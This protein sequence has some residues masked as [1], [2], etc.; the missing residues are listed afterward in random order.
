MYDKGIMYMDYTSVERVASRIKWVEIAA[1][2]KIRIKFSKVLDHLHAKGYIDFHGKS[3]D[4]AALSKFGVLYARGL[5][6]RK[7]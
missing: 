3:R 6:T 7:T 2:N 4:V 1:E 5:A